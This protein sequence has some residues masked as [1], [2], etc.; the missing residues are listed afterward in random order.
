MKIDKPS[1]FA[2]I[3]HLSTSKFRGAGIATYNLHR[4]LEDYGYFS[5]LCVQESETRGYLH[6][7]IAQIRKRFIS[8]RIWDR[9]KGIAKK[10][11]SNTQYCLHSVNDYRL[12][13][14]SD[15][16]LAEIP[17]VPD[18]IIVHWVS[19]FINAEILKSLYDKTNASIYWVMM[20]NAPITGGCHYPWS[21]D[22]YKKL[23]GNCPG[24][25]L[26][27][28]ND[29]THLNLS[30]KKRFLEDVDIS[31][32]CLS[33]SDYKRASQS[34]VFKDKPLYKML[35]PVD[36]QKFKIPQSK[37]V[38]KEQFGIQPDHKVLLFGASN[39][40]D[41]R[42]GIDIFNT[43]WNTVNHKNITILV[44]G[45][46]DKECLSELG[47]NTIYL[48]SVNEDK[49]S[50]CYQC[51][52]V[53]VC[54]TVEDSGPYM[55]NQSLMCGTPVVSFNIGVAMDLVITGETGYNCGEPSVAG[56]EKGITAIISMS[57]EDTDRMSEQC[58]AIA[59]EKCSVDQFVSDFNKML[60]SRS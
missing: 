8:D 10:E 24:L 25:N 52:D 20:D 59:I 19:G 33:E 13:D 3:L 7:K 45:K 22:G 18:I 41:K 60:S 5:Y 38:I 21:C 40:Q 51:A 35:L 15:K 26:N 14:C 57:R 16:I 42:K 48:G 31:I 49:L 6:Q 56:L 34:S 37:K 58:R 11:C 44:I 32:V 28:K 47:N 36:S 1:Q 46:A 43:A 29:I 50:L 23:C 9:L 39:V 27:G 53:F 17:F 2:N 55:I 54:P 4:Y 12:K 30:N